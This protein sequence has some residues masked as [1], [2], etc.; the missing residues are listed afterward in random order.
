MYI[1]KDSL[2]NT[3]KVFPNYRQA[4]TYKFAYGNQYWS[5]VETKKRTVD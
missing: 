2:G 1:V 4:S 5:I 3:M